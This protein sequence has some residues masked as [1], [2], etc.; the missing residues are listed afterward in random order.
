MLTPS[1]CLSLYRFFS[2]TPFS[3]YSIF[4]IVF[5]VTES[6]FARS[7][8]LMPRASRLALTLA[9]ISFLF[10]SFNSIAISVALQKLFFLPTF[11]LGVRI[12]RFYELTGFNLELLGAC[13]FQPTDFDKFRLFS[14]KVQLFGHHFTLNKC[15]AFWR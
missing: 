6:F 3:P 5:A 15:R 11:S 2:V 13:S 10:S 8:L 4:A 7:S 9:P 14:T 12:F 1:T